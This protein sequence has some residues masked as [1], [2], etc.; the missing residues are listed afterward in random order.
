MRFGVIL[1]CDYPNLQM[2]QPLEG[3]WARVYSVHEAKNQFPLVEK[4]AMLRRPSFIFQDIIQLEGNIR[5]I[6]SRS[7]AHGTEGELL[8][9]FKSISSGSARQPFL[10]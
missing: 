3:W 9:L 2:P 6:R 1:S 10:T 4:L 7:L 5:M 8:Y